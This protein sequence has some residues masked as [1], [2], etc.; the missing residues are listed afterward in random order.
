MELRASSSTRTSSGE[1][2]K[3]VEAVLAGLVAVL[4]EKLVEL[5]RT[6]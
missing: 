1:A 3:L 4:V 6:G 5:R 2:D